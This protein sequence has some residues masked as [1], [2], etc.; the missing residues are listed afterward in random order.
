[1]EE[2]FFIYK[3]LC[4]WHRICESRSYQKGT[5]IRNKEH[6]LDE[7]HWPLKEY[8]DFFEFCLR[9]PGTL[10]PYIQLEHEVPIQYREGTDEKESVEIG[11]SLT[12]F[13]HSDKFDKEFNP[14]YGVDI[15]TNDNLGIEQMREVVD[16]FT[17]FLDKYQDCPLLHLN[18]LVYFNV[19]SPSRKYLME[20]LKT[21]YSNGRHIIV[22]IFSIQKD[23]Q[24]F[25]M[26]HQLVLNHII[27]RRMHGTSHP[28]L[29]MV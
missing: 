9:Q 6:I 22:T 13:A 19:T 23:L 18:L 8:S 14:A 11:H 29:S 10:L 28:L 17:H 20:F 27:L 21:Q 24:W 3:G 4:T 2:L 16:K 26:D 1:M 12:V 15:R 25:L 5:V 7:L